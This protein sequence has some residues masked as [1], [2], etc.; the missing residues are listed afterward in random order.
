[1]SDDRLGI[2]LAQLNPCV[3]DIDGNL[4]LLRD[5]RRQAADA[6]A[7]I[8][9]AT[10]LVITGYPPEDL[11]QKP[12]FLDKAEAGVQ[13]LAA[14]TADGGPAVILGA[15]WR[16]NPETRKRDGHLYNAALVLDGGDV[17]AVRAKWDLPNYGVFD[18][19][20]LFTPGELPGPVELRGARL[21]LPICEDIWSEDVAECLQENGAEALIAIN[22]SPFESGKPDKRLQ[23]ALQRIAEC[24]IPLVYLNQVGGQDELVFDGASFVL[25]A[26]RNLRVQLPAFEPAVATTWWTRDRLGDLAVADGVRTDL[27]DGHAAIYRALVLGLRD[28]VDKNGFPG[29][30]LG[31]SG[32]IDSAISAVVAA[33]A[34]GSERVR[35]VLLPSPFTSQ[36]SLEDAAELAELLGCA[37]ETVDIGPAMQAFD[38][39]LKPLFDDLPTGIAEEN[40]QARSRGVALMAISNKFGPMVLSTGNKSEMSVGYSTLYGD[41]CGGF[42]AIKDVYKTQVYALAR[43][44]NQHLPHGSFG[45]AGRVIPERVITKAPSAELAPD[46]KDADS[47]PGYDQLDDILACLIESDMAAKE[48]AA[49][50]HEPDTVAKVWKLLEGAE[51]KRRQAPPG[52]K[53]TARNLSRDRRYPI[54]NKFR[55]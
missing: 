24:E 30:V 2:A 10:E 18:E 36:H 4:A 42:N 8:L 44:R 27:P 22:G 16:E 43:W 5:A 20:R 40:I 41:M 13:A 25:D 53:I 38:Q 47:L 19:K 14:D 34:L 1:M 23:L 45:P 52:V 15:P 33:D 51:Y 35:C 32:G 28:Y 7:D 49:R 26:G 48:I 11:V 9:V 55:G 50:G 21:G 54:V 39:M 3:G 6:G 12:A 29:V 17:R 37:L 31:L 46:Q